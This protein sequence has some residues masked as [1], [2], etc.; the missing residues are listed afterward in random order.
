MAAGSIRKFIQ[1]SGA[2]GRRPILRGMGQHLPSLVDYHEFK[3]QF[4]MRSVSTV[5]LS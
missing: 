2:L 1:Q 5:G 4:A 3:R